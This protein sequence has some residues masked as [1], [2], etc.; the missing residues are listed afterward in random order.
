MKQVKRVKRAPDVIYHLAVTTKHSARR[1]GRSIPTE[2]SR[3]AA[4]ANSRL[5]PPPDGLQFI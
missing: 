3:R 1:A 4:P 5:Q 2:V